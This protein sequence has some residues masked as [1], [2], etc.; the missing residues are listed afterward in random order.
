VKR[1]FDEPMGLRSARVGL[2]A[3][4]VP[5]RAARAAFEAAGVSLL[6]PAHADRPMVV[7]SYARD[8]GV[9]MNDLAVPIYAAGR[10]WGALRLAYRADAA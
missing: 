1:L 9:V 4:R 5:P 3:D 8:T 7:Q 10:R 6:R 2:N